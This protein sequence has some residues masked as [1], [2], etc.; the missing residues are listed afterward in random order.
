MLNRFRQLFNK[1]I[2]QPA[3]EAQEFIAKLAASDVW[4][5]A[6]GLRGA[7]AAPLVTDAASFSAAIRTLTPYR[8][9]L[10]E[11][12]DD[13]S[14]FPFNFRRGGR[15]I[16]PFFSS[17]ERAQEYLAD[18]G[19]ASDIAAVFQPFCLPSGFV[20]APHNDKFDLALD[21]RSPSERRIE[22]DERLLLRS[23]STTAE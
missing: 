1:Q 21:L 2:P 7:P 5:L 23:L 9:S 3:N 6:I 20:A 16:L 10:S 22:D 17:E 11:L 15:Q 13:N 12:G 18:S 19:F 8:K 14:V 4:I